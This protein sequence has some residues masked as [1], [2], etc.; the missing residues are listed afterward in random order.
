MRKT[1]YAIVRFSFYDRTGIQ[2]YL[3][4]Q[5]RKG[6]ML[7]KIGA[8]TWKFRRIEPENIH[9]AVTYF[10]GA[11]AYDPYP[12][13]HQEQFGEFCAHAGWLPAASNAQMQIFYNESD[14]PVPIETDAMMEVQNIHKAMKKSF[15]PS[16]I[17]LLLCAL[18]NLSTF[19]VD[20]NSSVVNTLSSGAALFR[21]LAWLT[22]ALM[23]LLE[24]GSYL[25][26]RRKALKAA[27]Q[28]GS[29][30][31]TRSPRKLIT[32]LLLLLLA[33]FWILFGS[34]TGPM[35]LVTAGAMALTVGIIAVTSLVR[36]K[37]KSAGVGKEENRIATT[38][39]TV[40]L[41]VAVI[42]LVTVLIFD[43]QDQNW[44]GAH[45]AEEYQYAISTYLRY[46]DPMPLRAEDLMGETDDK[47]SYYMET[48]STIFL[49]K[50]FAEQYHIL[51]SDGE[52]RLK[53]TILDVKLPLIYDAC[54]E[55]YLDGTY[56]EVDAEIWGVDSAYRRYLQGAWQNNYLLCTGDRIIILITYD[57]A[58]TQKQ[59]TI[60]GGILS[61]CE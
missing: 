48:Q 34:L 35:M 21:G 19:L 13:F 43:M 14:T 46:L 29:F 26:W 8:F 9:F 55:E 45:S 12:S 56:R 7:E 44:D 54:L 17:V 37:M 58:L 53:Y 52:Y 50:T 27:Q 60:A 2:N 1:K 42:F 57:H 22:V 31:E 16:Y 47:Y 61:N 28:D 5:A 18:L 40:V 23:E 10:P 11:T 20:L 32:A 49:R 24:I 15:L 59:M 33:A 36:D 4:S 39:I 25:I 6:W 41:T 3:E 30:V 51:G 38:I